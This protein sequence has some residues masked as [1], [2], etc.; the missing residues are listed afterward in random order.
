MWEPFTEGARRAIVLGHEEAAALGHAFIGSE[1]ILLGV[2]RQGGSVSARALEKRKVSVDGLRE[3]IT[4]LKPAGDAI[5]PPDMSF[6]PHAKRSIEVAFEVARS[7]RHNFVGEDHLFL[8]LIDLKEATAAGILG[9]LVPDVPALREEI[10]G[11]LGQVSRRGI[12]LLAQAPTPPR[13]E[14]R[15]LSVAAAQLGAADAP[16]AAALHAHGKEGFQIA[17]VTALA[18]DY[19]LITMQR[20]IAGSDPQFQ[21]M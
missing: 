18:D 11:L 17:A 16:D 7:F 9:S 21:P 4:A 13:F 12:G 5:E 15:F 10:S 8:A 3:Q 2:A 1:H 20:N 14:F 19:V 6:T